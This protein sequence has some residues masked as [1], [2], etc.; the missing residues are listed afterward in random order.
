MVRPEFQKYSPRSLPPTENL[1]GAKVYITGRR[2]EV[3]ENAAKTHT[4]GEAGDIIPVGPCDVTSKQDLE[5]LVKEISSKEK[6]INLLIANAGI[7]GPKG[8]PEA[9]D[10]TKLSTDLWKAE[11]PPE[12]SDVFNTNVTSPPKTTP[13]T[14]LAPPPSSSSAA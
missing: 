8:V 1:L 14:R 12:W 7:S 11:S 3:L 9:S 13:N 10:A 4:P 5:N 6:H 2:K